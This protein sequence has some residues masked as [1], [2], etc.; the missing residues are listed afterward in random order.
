MLLCVAAAASSWSGSVEYYVDV[1]LGKRTLAFPSAHLLQPTAEGDRFIAA[2]TRSV[3]ESNDVPWTQDQS[4]G[5]RQHAEELAQQSLAHA[6]RLS[7]DHQRDFMTPARNSPLPY[8][9]RES[10]PAR[11]V[12]HVHAAVANAR[13]GISALLGNPGVLD[14]RGMSDAHG[15][16]VCIAWLLGLP[17]QATECTTPPAAGIC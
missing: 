15:R 9:F 7:A 2:A 5:L 8:S 14:V 17:A 13:K 10:D 12:G 3:F 4:D 11:L 6:N 16:F 1:G